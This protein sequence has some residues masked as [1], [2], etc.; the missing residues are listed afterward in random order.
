MAERWAR[1]RQTPGWASVLQQIQVSAGTSILPNQKEK[2]AILVTTDHR[3]QMVVVWGP[4]GGCV[5]SREVTHTDSP[6]Q[7]C[8]DNP[9]IRP[10]YPVQIWPGS[11]HRQALL[12]K[13]SQQGHLPGFTTG[14]LSRRP[15]GKALSLRCA[16]G[17]Q[18]WTSAQQGEWEEGQRAEGAGL[19]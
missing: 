11:W 17:R 16:G 7:H 15:P 8:N 19:P 13:A 3:G 12:Q 10:G 18:K 1:G 9:T 14:Q 5:L 6:P 2:N 4:R